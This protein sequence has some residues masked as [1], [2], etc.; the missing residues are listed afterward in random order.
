[1]LC[2]VSRG[3]KD[4]TKEFLLHLGAWLCG[5]SLFIPLHSTGI[6]KQGLLLLNFFMTLTQLKL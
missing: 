5:D 4:S 3:S 2:A 1:M 6:V